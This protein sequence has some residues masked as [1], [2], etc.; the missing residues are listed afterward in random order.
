LG[1]KNGEMSGRTAQS[2]FRFSAQPRR[3][4]ASIAHDC[5]SGCGLAC[6]AGGIQLFLAGYFSSTAWFGF[7]LFYSCVVLATFLGG[8][9]A[10][11]S[12]AV[13]SFLLLQSSLRLPSMQALD[14][15][16]SP[17]YG[18]AREMPGLLLLLNGLAVAHL[19]SWW[20]SR[21]MQ[22]RFHHFR[23][24]SEAENQA[25]FDACPSA[26]LA[27]GNRDGLILRVNPRMQ[28]ILGYSPAELLGKS[29][30]M[31]VP[32]AVR[33]GHPELRK[34]YMKNPIPKPLGLGR[35]LYARHKDG[36]EVPVEISLIPLR[37]HEEQAVLV[38]I[39]DISVRKAMEAGVSRSLEELK[40]LQAETRALANRL[41]T[42]VE[43]A[44]QGIAMFDTRMRYLLASK[45]WVHDYGLA[46]KE[47][48][49]VSHYELFPEI[50]ERWKEVHRR[51]LAG[52]SISSV[53]DTFDRQ[54]GRTQRLRWDVR[55]WRDGV[56][57]IGG[58]VIFA[59]DI[60]ENFQAR[61]SASAN[62]L[63]LQT[64]VNST[65]DPIYLKDRQG[66]MRLANAAAL[67]A[68]GEPAEKVIGKNALEYFENRDDAEK[69]LQ[70]DEAVMASGCS[71]L[72]EE[73]TPYNKVFLT[74]R[75]PFRDNSGNVVGVVG[76]ARDIT[77][78]KKTEKDLAEAFEK[79][80]Q[81]LEIRDEF[82]SLASHELKTPLAA[83]FL[84][85]NIQERELNRGGEV[86]IS[87]ENRKRDLELN[88]RQFLRLKRL[89]DDMLDVSRINSGRLSLEREDFDLCQLVQATAGR[90]AV[91]CAQSGVRL[92]VGQCEPIVGKWDSLRIE[93]VVLNLL[94]NALKYGEGSD[95]FIGVSRKDER[96]V[97]EVRDCG[98]GIDLKDHDRIFHRFERAITGTNISGLGLGLYIVHSIV[99]E[100]GGDIRV[101]SAPGKGARFLVELPL[102]GSELSSENASAVAGDQ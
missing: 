53:D 87:V 1:D 49:G 55:P 31:L 85:L 39:A 72:S 36:H 46:G 33:P 82:I 28:E 76:V 86:V 48:L 11:V 35:D 23:S 32:D 14:A 30:D 101:E 91:N 77:D 24:Q 58:I 50:P 8:K 73:T 40:K 94:D 80:K 25:L 63:L 57:E 6:L 88:K 15:G 60:T 37:M 68:I 93:Q 12:A 89:V 96:A 102:H 90:F 43:N 69:V 78:R 56:G 16:A 95:I 34:Q 79:M 7:A 99:K 22:Q 81:A 54:S 38:S 65:P 75:T 47:I 4:F 100:H 45:R 52:E 59:E 27:V 41:Q 74:T 9:S 18:L 26:L 70:S 67:E 17:V 3:A 5:V 62:Q 19:P 10:G 83:L 92:N 84:Q 44:P 66:K 97:I 51:C 20:F 64:V 71:K 42:I 29:V 13:V 98:R 21:S 2:I 61:E